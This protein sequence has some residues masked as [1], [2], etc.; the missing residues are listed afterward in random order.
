[1]TYLI[2][3][4]AIL[5][6]LLFFAWLGYRKGLVLTLCGFLSIFVA[7]IGAFA[8]SGALAEPAASAIK[9]VFEDHI[10]D[11]LSA[12]IEDADL[13]S[14][15]EV[16]EGLSPDDLMEYLE[17]SDLYRD[18]TW[19]L[20]EV[21]VEIV[22]TVFFILAFAAILA[23]WFILSRALDLVSKLPVIGGVNQW[24]GGA[25]GLIKGVMMVF[26]AVWLFHPLLQE[27]QE[28]SFLL[29]FFCTVNPLSFFL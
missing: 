9:P 29:K 13:S 15:D 14:L 21:T 10:W 7:F 16:P 2:Y 11:A 8:V 22:R 23:A 5:I 27:A 20:H 19:S 25:A 28:N 1:M 6:V 24:A 18:F 17:E 12:V 26:I 3:D 4:L